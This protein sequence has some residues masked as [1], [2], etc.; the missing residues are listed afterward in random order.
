MTMAVDIL[1]LGFK[2]D[3]AQV[4]TASK[5]LDN[6]SRSAKSSGASISKMGT[7]AQQASKGTSTLATSVRGLIGV[8]AGLASVKALIG[9][10]DDY[11]KLTAQLKLA[12]RSQD[13]FSAAFNNVQNIA[14]SAQASLS[15][16]AMLY[17]RISNATRSLG[18]NQT[19]VSAITESVAL[20]L[21]VSGASAAEASSSMMQLSQAFGLGAL[22]SEEFNAVSESNPRIMLA[23]ADAMGVT[24]SQLKGLAGE[25][26]ITSDVLGN[27]L[28]KALVDLK[29]EAEQTKTIGGAFVD[30][31]NNILLTA[32]GLDQAT[33]ASKAFAGAIKAISDSG[34]IRIIF[35]TI[36]VLGL[37]VAFVFKTIA[38]EIVGFGKQL[39][40]LSNLDFKGAIAIGDQVGKDAATARVEL[41]KLIES[42]LNPA[43]KNSALK[44]EIVGLVLTK[45]YDFRNFDVYD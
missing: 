38:N 37:N 9:I 32:G 12:T 22:K 44:E 15:E 45:M 18:A 43:V 24:I 3:T 36:A 25:G 20:A 6:L 17:A 10:A 11:T 8:Y 5:D 2:V 34:A 16:T 7:D 31:K 29:K 13:E 39:Q 33:G 28:T 30:L 21:K 41:D 40:A 1:N 27:A 4:K 35:E 23:I 26:K 42:I 19:T 14:K